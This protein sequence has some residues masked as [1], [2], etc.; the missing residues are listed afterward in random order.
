MAIQGQNYPTLLEVSKQFS[1]DGKPLPIAELLSET[2]PILDDIPFFEAN[3]TNGHRISVRAGY[4]DAAWR[5]LNAGVSPSKSAYAD[6]TESMGMLSSLGV[7]DKKLAELSPNVAQF[8]LNENKGHM[9]AM[10]QGFAQTLIYGD[11]DVSPEQFL[12]LAPRF[13]SLSADNAAQIIDAGGTGT[14]LAS[15]WLIGWGESSAFGIYP[16]GSQAGLVHKDMGENLIDDGTGKQYP[17]LRDWFEWDG[18]IAVKDWRNIVRIA[19][20]DTAALTKDANA[21]ADLIDL[22]VQGIEQINARESVN[23]VGYAP[24]EIR[25]FLR[26]QITNKANVWLSMDEVAGRKVVSFDGMP[27]RRV[28][29]LLTTESRV[30]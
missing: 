29:K 10:N 12:G 8:R 17:A 25:A 3:S 19:N 28:D 1:A 24:R 21:G 2:N 26:R 9:E 30:V 13:D 4:P 18:G 6:V 23:L 15:I 14:D 11:T 22:I 27:F 16:K 5:K 7:C 20:I